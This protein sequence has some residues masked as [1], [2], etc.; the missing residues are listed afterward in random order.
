VCAVLIHGIDSRHEMAQ[1][2]TRTI[3]ARVAEL[4]DALDLGSSPARGAGSNPVSRT[5]L[6]SKDL[7]QKPAGLSS[8][9]SRKFYIEFYISCP[10]SPWPASPEGRAGDESAPLDLSELEA[11][12]SNCTLRAEAAARKA[13]F[14]LM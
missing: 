6:K 10:G 3:F 4:A 14:V 8:A 7:R 5:W 11:P 2:G 9:L 13:G 12:S 1:V